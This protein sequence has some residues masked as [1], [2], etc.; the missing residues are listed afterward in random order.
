L[1]APPT[2]R[3]NVVRAFLLALPLSALLLAGCGGDDGDMASDVTPAATETT[4]SAETTPPAETT[5]PREDTVSDDGA[6]EDICTQLA[7]LADIDPDAL[8]TQADIDR[9]TA[10]AEA[11]P[12]EIQDELTTL[13][14][15]GQLI[16]DTSGAALEDPEAFDELTAATTSPEVT[17]A[18]EAL[19]AYSAEQCG[20]EI[21]LF[22]SFTG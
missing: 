21:P 16:A 19:V 3:N 2:T 10:V 9:L 1:T 22:T 14:D 5:V 6:S 4:P 12:P 11:A 18:G 7:D 20:I 15:I 17:A 13:A 8:P